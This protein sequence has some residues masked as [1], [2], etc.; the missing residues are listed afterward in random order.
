MA[1]GDVHFEGVISTSG[2]Q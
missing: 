2:I 1:S